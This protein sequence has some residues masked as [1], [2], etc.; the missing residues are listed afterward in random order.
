MLDMW[1]EECHLT[2]EVI[3]AIAEIDHHVKFLCFH[4]FMND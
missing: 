1:L 3:F 2:G 4:A